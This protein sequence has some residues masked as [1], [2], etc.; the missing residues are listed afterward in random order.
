MI[1]FL[2]V[3]AAIAFT[4]FNTAREEKIQTID[5]LETVLLT[6]LSTKG[7]FVTEAMIGMNPSSY[8][9]VIM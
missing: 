1:A 9:Q 4:N 2:G 5:Y 7:A 6:E 8:F 3:T